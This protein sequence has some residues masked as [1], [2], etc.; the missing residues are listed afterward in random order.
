MAVFC[1][2]GW[3][4]YIHPPWNMSHYSVVDHQ[5]VVGDVV[6][7]TYVGGFICGELQT[8][9]VPPAGVRFYSHFRWNY[10]S[11]GT[12]VGD[13]AYL[14]IQRGALASTRKGIAINYPRFSGLGR[15]NWLGTIGPDRNVKI[16]EMSFWVQVNNYDPITQYADVTLEAEIIDGDGN[17][18][19]YSS[20]IS[21]YCA[22]SICFGLYNPFGNPALCEYQTDYLVAL[23]P[24][25][26]EDCL[27][28]IYADFSATPRAA[29]KP[30]TIT[31]TDLS[32]AE[33]GITSWLWDFG[34]GETSTD[35][36]PV[37]TY[38]NPGRYTV[39]LTVTGPDGQSSKTE[40][41]FIVTI[42]LGF[43]AIP[44]FGKKPLLVRFYQQYFEDGI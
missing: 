17:L 2:I 16:T 36:N 3:N 25:L 23:D 44:A 35:Q 20:T 39:T 14:F 33:N 19:T 7:S 6:K 4:Y 8:V 29:V 34:D 18:V 15:L 21:Y 11:G 24:T 1:P 38:T 10:Y 9:Q 12:L 30:A 42:G 43:T 32:Q 41:S 22:A 37:H 5:A 13:T 27:G 31:F 28:L 26:P 40:Q